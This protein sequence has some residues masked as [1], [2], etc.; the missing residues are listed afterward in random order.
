VSPLAQASIGSTKQIS[1]VT[2]NNF[3]NPVIYTIKAEDG[4]TKNYTVTVS[5][6][7]GVGTISPSSVQHLSLTRQTAHLP[8]M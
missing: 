2:T 1:S 5:K 6:N 4:T 7:T 3:T 8:L